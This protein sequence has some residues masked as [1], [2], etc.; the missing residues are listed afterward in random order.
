MKKIILYLALT[1][2]LIST[3][4]ALSIRIDDSAGFDN[5][6]FHLTST[7]NRLNSNDDGLDYVSWGNNNTPLGGNCTGM[8]RLDSTSGNDPDECGSQ[9]I[10]TFNSVT[11]GVTGDTGSLGFSTGTGEFE[12]SAP[13]DKYQY[14]SRSWFGIV[15]WDNVDMGGG[16][17]FILST[18]GGSNTGWWLMQCDASPDVLRHTIAYGGGEEHA[19]MNL[20]TGL[21]DNQYYCVGG[22]HTNGDKHHLWINHSSQNA[23]APAAR[24]LSASSSA[25]TFHDHDAA[26]GSN[27]AGDSGMWL[28]QNRSMD[29]DDFNELCQVYLPKIN[30]VPRYETECFDGGQILNFDEFNQSVNLSSGMN[31]RGTVCSYSD[32]ACTSG[33]SCIELGTDELTDVS[34]MNNAQYFKYNA[35][36]DGIEDAG[37]ITDQAVITSLTVSYTVASTALD[38]IVAPSTTLET[39]VTEI[40]LYINSTNVTATATDTAILYFN[41]SAHVMTLRDNNTGQAIF[42]ASVDIPLVALDNS[43]IWYNLTYNVTSNFGR[44]ENTTSMQNITVEWAYNIVNFTMEVNVTELQIQNIHANLDKSGF[45]NNILQ[46]VTVYHNNTIALINTSPDQTTFNNSFATAIITDI[47]AR[48]EIINQINFSLVHN[49]YRETR[50]ITR[51]QNITVLNINNC[52][53]ADSPDLAFLIREE[54]TIDTAIAANLDSTFIA[55]TT[56]KALNKTVSFG[57]SGLDTY[58]YCLDFGGG[59]FYVESTQT[60]YNDQYATRNYF[61]LNE[62]FDSAILNN[63][64]LYM[65]NASDSN[66]IIATVTDSDNLPLSDH[67]VEVLRYYED[68]NVFRTIEISR[69]DVNGEALMHLAA[70]AG[71]EPF[72]QLIIKDQNGEVLKVTNP[73]KIVQSSINIQVDTID[74]FIQILDQVNSISRSLTF[75][76]ATRTA[77]FFYSDPNNIVQEGTIRATKYTVRGTEIICESTVS[78]PSSTLFCNIGNSTGEIIIQGLVTRYDGQKEPLADYSLSTPNNP[79]GKYGLLIFFIEF[80]TIGGVGLWHPVA[81]IIYG[82]IVIIANVVMGF[83]PLSYTAIV[84]ILIMIFAIIARLR[85]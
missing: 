59:D 85:T 51:G 67:Y 49:G 37:S 64:T 72:Y 43:L 30:D 42:N 58:Y 52:T 20:P 17:H 46:N 22:S 3:A 7:D 65:L 61:L 83:I 74:S 23:T 81:A 34:S 14:A 9:D 35:S 53:L 50:S 57:E 26:G 56:D 75:N 77:T 84:M 48:V 63:V 15:A 68:E 39:N 12:I 69:T 6:T 47:V 11:R 54:E 19:G 36:W 71:T 76:N 10:D 24:T 55:W 44:Y 38:R 40:L 33:A 62:T 27:F 32:S 4:S 13:E 66:N 25:L 41:N 28:I 16:C 80:M 31:I 45:V 18:Y 82:G 70:L 2:L 1:L 8:W 79:Y 78:S 5:G 29:A 60:Y 21:V 73:A